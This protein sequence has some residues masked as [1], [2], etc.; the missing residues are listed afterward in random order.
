MHPGRHSAGVVK[1]KDRRLFDTTYRKMHVL[2]VRTY[3]YQYDAESNRTKRTDIT[4]GA[5]TE[6][7]WDHHNRLTKITERGDLGSELH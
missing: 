3:D 4:T 1:E 6:Y 7:T 2:L 5:V